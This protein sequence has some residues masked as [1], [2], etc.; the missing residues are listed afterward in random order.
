ME[1][2]ILVAG[3]EIIPLPRRQA[4]EPRVPALLGAVH[5]PRHELVREPL[6]HL[7]AE[8]LRT[9]VVHQHL[10]E[11]VHAG[12]LGQLDMLRGCRR[13]RGGLRRLSL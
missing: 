13:G 3:G 11:V 10:T 4:G 7:R 12:D 8:L 6:R 9:V 5:T 2:V 1:P